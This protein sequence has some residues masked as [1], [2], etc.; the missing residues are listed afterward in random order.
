MAK[1]EEDLAET[2]AMVK[3]LVKSS[4]GDE[5]RDQMPLEEKDGK[6]HIYIYMYI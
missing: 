2:T 4:Q 5:A 1:I 3:T 6:G